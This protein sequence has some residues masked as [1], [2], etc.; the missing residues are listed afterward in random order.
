MD[1]VITQEGKKQ[2]A[3][4]KMQ[5]AYVSFTDAATFYEPDIVSGSSDASARIFFEHCN[6]PQD[7][8]TLKTDESGKLETFVNSDGTQLKDGRI[9]SY[10]FDGLTA[11]VLTGSNQSLRFLRGNEF[12]DSANSLLLSS[13]DNFAK[14]RLIGTH[15]D[16]FDDDGFGVGNKNIEFVITPDKPI[17][18]PSRY[19]A[20]INHLEN[21]FA[22]IRLARVDNFKFLPPVNK[23]ESDVFAT[24]LGQYLPWSG[25]YPLSL[26]ARQLESEL[27]YLDQQ[28][29]SKTIIFDPTSKNN[30]L[31]AQF[32]E[33]NFDTITKLD[34][35]E[36]GQFTFANGQLKHYFFV[37]KVLQN[38]HGI[39]TFV[40]LFTLVFG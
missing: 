17:G 35:I 23:T 11:S 22:D 13:V 21:L 5:V 14:L 15:D 33:V 16:V 32:F 8:I 39:Q 38:A 27:A 18:D 19:T 12:L 7:Q 9:V 31:I 6:L 40:H 3:T 1:T 10:S 24:Q 29:S 2:L 26:V 37:G 4:G 34:V 36:Y 25:T 30:R 20:N 28:G